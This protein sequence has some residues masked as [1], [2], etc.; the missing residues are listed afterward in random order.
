[1]EAPTR[2]EYGLEADRHWQ[3][4]MNLAEQFGF[5]VQ[6][7]GGTALLV[8]HRVQLEQ[9]GEAGYLRIQQTAGHCPKDAGYDG[10]LTDDGQLKQCKNCLYAEGAKWLGFSRNPTWE[11][12]R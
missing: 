10:C 4:V 9:Y 5:I 3:E 11:S 6:A 12:R 1:M 8:T 2:K 7:Y